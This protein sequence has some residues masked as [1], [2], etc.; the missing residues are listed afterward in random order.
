MG[1]EVP[2]RYRGAGWTG[3]AE[4]EGEGPPEGDQVSHQLQQGGG[5]HV[6]V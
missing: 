4:G 2:Q 1:E 5:L 3:S 6:R